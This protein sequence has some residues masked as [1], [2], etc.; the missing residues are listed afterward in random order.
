MKAAVK[1]T[2]RAISLLTVLP[3]VLL[4]GI[5]AAVIGSDKAFPGWSQL[6][7][8]VPGMLGV[9]LRHAFYRC[10]L[11]RCAPDACVG[12]GTLFSHPNAAVGATT[13]IGNYCS[14]GDVDIANDVLIA[15]HVS[16]LNGCNQHGIDRL[17]IPVREQVGVYDEVSIGEDTWI[18][19]RATIAASIGKHCVVGAG[20]LVLKPLP[21]YAVAVGVP[22]KIIRDRRDIASADQA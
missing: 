12:F 3:A 14:I 19:E 10:S 1:W 17:D 9:Y 4:Y 20:A 16:I 21:D 7:S 6:F 5:H 22:A 11:R 18:G 8:T 13:Y 2:I 15:S